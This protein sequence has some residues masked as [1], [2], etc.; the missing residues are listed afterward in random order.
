MINSG[1]AVPCELNL[2]SWEEREE[3][4]LLG[5]DEEAE[6]LEEAL[7]TSAAA[8]ISADAITRRSDEV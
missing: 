2:P 1:G 6:K 4:E 3:R 7:S 8:K 5:V